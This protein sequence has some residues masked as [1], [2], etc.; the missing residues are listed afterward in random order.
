[1]PERSPRTNPFLRR[2]A[3]STADGKR[4]S[5]VHVVDLPLSEY[6]RFELETYRESARAG[7]H[8][9]IAERRPAPQL[10]ALQSISGCSTP[11][12]ARAVAVFLEYD[13]AGITSGRR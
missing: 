1:M 9:G 12:P 10:G 4:W 2:I 8:I 11:R 13:P 7:E 3:E 5:R 6:V